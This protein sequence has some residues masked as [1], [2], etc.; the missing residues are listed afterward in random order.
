M[1]TLQ[2]KV[3][4]YIVVNDGV[5]T[6]DVAADIGN[7]R[8]VVL[9]REDG[10]DVARATLMPAVRSLIGAFSWEVFASRSLPAASW[11]KLRS[12]DHII[13]REGNE[14]F[15]G[16][17]AVERSA[18]AS[19]GRG[20]D[21]R[22]HDGTTLDFILAGVAAALPGATRINI[23]LT[24][25]L[26]ISLWHLAPKVSE[27]LRGSHAFKYNGRDVRVQILSVAVRREAEAA[28]ASLDGDTSGRLLIIDGGGRTVNMALFSNGEYKSGITL[29]LGVEAALDNVD[30]AMLGQGGR[31]LTL[32]ERAE[33]LDALITGKEYSI[34]CE[35]KSIPVHQI[36]R[37][38]FDATA[39]ALVQ[40]V[41][42]KIPGG[43]SMVQRLVFVGG[44]AYPALFGSAVKKELP[45]CETGGLRELANAYG[46]MAVKK[47]A[48]KK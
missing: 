12:D 17:L 31:I 34:I 37:S 20:S 38:Q 22:Y 32:A 8:A 5:V 26:P 29:E 23:R 21:A 7:A 27:S 46:A 1:T 36:A 33:L 48:K 44:A 41:S 35:G 25:M 2:E 40:E 3:Q 10:S 24:T 28:Y 16:R 13:E 11:G 6:A 42:S 47:V 43:P 30:K 9:V 18:A 15:L 14:R 19:S 4:E 45:I 39:H